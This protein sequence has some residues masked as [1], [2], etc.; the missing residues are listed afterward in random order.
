MSFPL[1]SNDVSMTFSS[2]LCL[3]ITQRQGF[4]QPQ[5]NRAHRCPRFVVSIVCH[6]IMIVI[7]LH[8][9]HVNARLA[10]NLQGRVRPY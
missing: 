3:R 6:T 4:K 5:I 2:A 9:S 8:V 1:V 10:F 7:G